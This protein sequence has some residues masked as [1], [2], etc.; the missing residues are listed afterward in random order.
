MVAAG[1]GADEVHF[2]LHA[3]DVKPLDPVPE[4]LQDLEVGTVDIDLEIV[5]VRPAA[6]GEEVGQHDRRR[7]VGELGHLPGIVAQFLG[8]R[9]LAEPCLA[10]L[11][12]AHEAETLADRQDQ[13]RRLARREVDLAVGVATNEGARHPRR[14][15]RGSQAFALARRRRHDRRRGPKARQCDDAACT[16][17]I[18][19]PA[20]VAGRPR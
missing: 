14:I 1:V 19:Q 10:N 17:G 16:A 20:P 7:R 13:G 2:E 8:V 18:E 11:V 12:G 9:G 4:R 6:G 5:E 3:E 15:A